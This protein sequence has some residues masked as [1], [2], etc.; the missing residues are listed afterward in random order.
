MKKLFFLLCLVSFSANSAI[1]TCSDARNVFNKLINKG[2]YKVR[3][4]FACIKSTE[5]D[6]N[7]DFS[8]NT[9]VITTAR[10]GYLMNK[11]EL[12]ITIGHELGHYSLQTGNSKQSESD[13]D[14]FGVNLSNKAG[15]NSCKGAE[16]L[17]YFLEDEEHA[18]GPERYK[19]VKCK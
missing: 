2:G 14:Q 5:H 7:Y 1:L 9:I 8:T 6:A 19:R 12:A 3:P 4:Y 13:A 16:L 17:N 11:D 10:L 18:A 15:Y